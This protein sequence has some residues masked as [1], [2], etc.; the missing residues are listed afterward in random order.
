MFQYLMD[1]IDHTITNT[2]VFGTTK[3]IK[4]TISSSFSEEISINEKLSAM[5][6]VINSL[7]NKIGS[8]TSDL[9]D[10]LVL[11]VKIDSTDDKHK[12]ENSDTS[13]QQK[14]LAKQQQQPKKPKMAFGFGASLPSSSDSD[15]VSTK[16]PNLTSDGAIKNT[17]IT[18]DVVNETKETILDINP[19]D[20][21]YVSKNDTLFVIDEIE[22]DQGKYE[23]INHTITSNIMESNGSRSHD[24]ASSDNVKDTMNH[25]SSISTKD[26]PMII[27][28]SIR[29]NNS[30]IN[31]PSLSMNLPKLYQ[32]GQEKI[33]ETTTSN[34]NDM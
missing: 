33:I 21:L 12:T 26:G 11:D 7:P 25:T 34:E 20:K 15:G 22:K 18:V 28:S 2:K 17:N 29:A 30:G 5:Q 1:S 23:T 24:R 13:V 10:D 3:T 4:N 31:T 27:D 14:E 19:I 9:V 16:K 8:S 6:A 32:P